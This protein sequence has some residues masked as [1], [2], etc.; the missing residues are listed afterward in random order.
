MTSDTWLDSW[1]RACSAV[2][3]SCQTSDHANRPTVRAIRWDCDIQRRRL[4]LS[5]SSSQKNL[6][7]MNIFCYFVRHRQGQCDA[8]FIS[9]V[10]HARTHAR[11]L[12]AIFVH[13][14]S[15]QYSSFPST[16]ISGCQRTN[17]LNLNRFRDPDRATVFAF[18]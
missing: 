18:M 5:T 8:H 14:A 13:S 15:E 16:G 2:S 10:T 11:T 17:E 9:A 7:L 12:D 6:A 4:Y 1:Y 3:D